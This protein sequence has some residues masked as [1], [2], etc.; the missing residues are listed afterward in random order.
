LAFPGFAYSYWTY[1][2]V[3]LFVGALIGYSLDE[4]THF[5]RQFLIVAIALGVG[6]A[7][8][9]IGFASLNVLV[10]LTAP[11]LILA[12][13]ALIYKIVKTVQQKSLIGQRLFA[14]AVIVLLLGVFI[15]AGAKTVITLADVKANTPQE[16]MQF[17]IAVTNVRIENSTTQVYNSQ[18]ESLTPEYSI[19]KADV[20]IQQSDKTSQGTLSASLY[21]NYG[22]V[23]KPLIVTTET[24]DIYAHLELT[25]SLYNSLV[26]T[27]SGS[28]VTPN[29]LS[30][31]IQNSPM[32]YLVWA[33]VVFIAFSI[34]IQFARDLSLKKE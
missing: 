6:V 8:S 22:L 3:V 2:F 16:A 28:S 30:I 25:E 12:F 14:L 15:S 32:I 34:L 5:A 24:G 29:D 21:P 27:L 11:L 17:E 1:P 33:G 18:T 9:L 20:T 10:T 7:I 23:I 13:F 19:L 31:T 4:K 26:Q